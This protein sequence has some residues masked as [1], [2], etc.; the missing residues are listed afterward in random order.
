M[1]IKKTALRFTAASNVLNGHF[2]PKSAKD[3]FSV[4]DIFYVHFL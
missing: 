3:D 1:N 2:A 4:K